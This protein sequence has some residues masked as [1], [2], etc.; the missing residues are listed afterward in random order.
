M[1]SCLFHKGYLLSSHLPSREDLLDLLMLM[2]HL[3]LLGLT[4]VSP[5]HQIVAWHEVFLTR[6][7]AKSNAAMQKKG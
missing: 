4:R 2:K 5:V 7:G 3:K 1:G 6:R